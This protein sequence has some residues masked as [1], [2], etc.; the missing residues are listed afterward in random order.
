MNDGAHSASLDDG[1][2][3]E[4]NTG[5]GDRICLYREQMT[6]LIHGKPDCWQRTKPEQKETNKIMDFLDDGKAMT[7]IFNLLN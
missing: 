1:P 4:Q 3:H 2:D 7:C 5:D 6:D